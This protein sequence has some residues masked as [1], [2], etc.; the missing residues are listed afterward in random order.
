[1]TVLSFL[2]W[3]LILGV[4][5]TY[6]GY[7][8][9]AAAWVRLK[10]RPA[11]RA[12]G[13]DSFPTVAMIVP[14][15]NEAGII[16]E[17][18]RNSLAQDYPSDKWKL[19]VVTDGSTD[20]TAAIAGAFPGLQHF[21]SQERKGK[22]AAINRVVDQLNDAEILVFSDANTMLNPDALNFLI[23]HY[24]DPKVGGVSGEKKVQ[25]VE[26]HEVGEEGIYWKYESTLKKLDAELYSIVGAAGEL[27][28]IRRELY[29]PIPEDT[30]LDDFVISMQIC[31]R[32]YII[33]YE[34]R[35]F[36]T[37]RPSQ[38]MA[39]ERQRKIRISAGAFQTMHRLG[40]MANPFRYG[41]LGFQFLSR[42]VMRWVFCPLALPLIFFINIFLVLSDAQPSW[43]YRLTLILQALLYGMAMIGRF[44]VGRSRG[45]SKLFSLAY[46]F[47]FMNLSVWEGFFRYVKGTQSALWHKARR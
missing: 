13:P 43:L 10:G 41:I 24:R 7:G 2:F 42:R 23:A 38:S 33:R 36:A 1:M 40:Y 28:S 3:L 5:Y 19:V 6:A 46:Y 25:A 18:I 26:G 14:A 29:E 37:E 45:I 17:K 12:E 35:A 47:V 31:A 30:L 21:H 11:A 4:L 22:V 20:E 39:D 27:F 32:G 9:L 34:P 15:Y 44:T 8:I 16:A